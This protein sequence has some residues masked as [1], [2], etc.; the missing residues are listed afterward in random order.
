MVSAVQWNRL[1]RESLENP[2]LSAAGV[3]IHPRIPPPPGWDPDDETWTLNHERRAREE[4]SRG[5]IQ[6][7]RSQEAAAERQAL[8]SSA[9]PQYVIREALEGSAAARARE[10]QIMTDAAAKRER[11]R[12]DAEELERKSEE[13]ARVQAAIDNADN[14]PTDAIY[15]RY[16]AGTMGEDQVDRKSVV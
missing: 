11:D 5:Q 4:S 15:A 7:K 2:T 1:V 8:G 6:E 16:L 9:Q 3:N 13:A 10:A 14:R 12:L